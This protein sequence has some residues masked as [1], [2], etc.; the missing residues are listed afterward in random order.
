M[1]Y[2]AENYEVIFGSN[3][4]QECG[5]VLELRGKGINKQIIRFRVGEDGKVL[6]NCSV[7]DESGTTITKVANS[8]VQHLRQG[9]KAD[10]SSSAIKVWNES[11]GEVWLEFVELGPRKFKLNGIFYLPGYKIVARDEYLDIN[12]N[13]IANC[14]FGSCSAAIGLA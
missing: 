12:T 10:I 9:F 7:K 8:K 3:L 13:R 11:T 4:I 1:K 14:S 2:E 6:F 5:K